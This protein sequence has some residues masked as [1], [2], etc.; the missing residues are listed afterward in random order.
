MKPHKRRCFDCQSI[1][2]HTDNVA[3][4]VRC[5]KCGSY[6]TRAIKSVRKP[7]I[8]VMS[9]FG[10]ARVEVTDGVHS[11]AIDLTRGEVASLAESLQAVLELSDDL[12]EIREM[13]R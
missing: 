1:A 6:D 9:A 3:P 4:D 13:E 2:T 5:R 7:G 10:Q 11:I 8:R 12:D